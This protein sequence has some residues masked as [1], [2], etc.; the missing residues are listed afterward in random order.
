MR[1][2]KPGD[3]VYTGQIIGIHNHPNDLTVNCLV[4]KKLT[5]I[6][7]AMADESI[8]LPPLVHI[9]LEQSMGLISDDELIEV[10]PHSIRL[11]KKNLTENIGYVGI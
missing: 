3:K 7:S 9:T 2:I 8:V 6:R 5:N 11:R 10:T 4:G 1:F